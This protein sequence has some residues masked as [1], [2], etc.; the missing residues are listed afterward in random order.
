MVAVRGNH[1]ERA[2]GELATDW[3]RPH[4]RSTGPRGAELQR[5]CAVLDAGDPGYGEAHPATHLPPP[6]NSIVLPES[7]G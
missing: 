6:S 7:A 4:S 5:P 3:R 2:K 1:A